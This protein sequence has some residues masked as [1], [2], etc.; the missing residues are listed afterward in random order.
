M[1]TKAEPPKAETFS[2]R[3]PDDVRRQVDEIARETAR[4]RADVIKD[5]V[6]AY[7]RDQADYLR[8]LDAA[9]ESAEGGVGHSA[10]QIFGWMRSWGTPVERPSP[11]PDIRPGR[12]TS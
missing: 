11:T 9:V 5:A 12:K 10:E 6:V 8:D 7:V 4:S 2:L 1:S 3:L